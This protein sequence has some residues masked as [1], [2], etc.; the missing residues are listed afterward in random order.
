MSNYVIEY[1]C[2]NMQ[3]EMISDLTENIVPFSLPQSTVADVLH[4]VFH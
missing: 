2:E 1:L 4:C 3:R